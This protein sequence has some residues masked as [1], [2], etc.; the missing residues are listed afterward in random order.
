MKNTK[1]KLPTWLFLVVIGTLQACGTGVKDAESD[2]KGKGPTTPIVYADLGG[3]WLIDNRRSRFRQFEEG[4]DLSA[5][6]SA[7]QKSPYAISIDQKQNSIQI[8]DR[9][10]LLLGS[11]NSDK[12]AQWSGIEPMIGFDRTLAIRAETDV[13]NDKSFKGVFHWTVFETLTD[14]TEPQFVC[15]ASTRF[16]AT[17]ADNNTPAV[18][19]NVEAVALSKRAVKIAWQDNANNEWGY[20]VQRSL[21][22]NSD[23]VDL[24]NNGRTRAN[25]T[26]LIDR[27]ELQAGETYYYRVQALHFSGRSA[28]SEVVSVVIPEESV[29]TPSQITNLNIETYEHDAVRL[30][31]SIDS[32]FEDGI[33]VERK[34]SDSNYFVPVDEVLL[35]PGTTEFIDRAISSGSDRSV[36][37]RI[38][39]VNDLIPETDA[40]LVANYGVETD[41]DFKPEG[42]HGEISPVTQIKVDRIKER[43]AWLSWQHNAKNTFAYVIYRRGRTDADYQLVGFSHADSPRFVDVGLNRDDTYRYKIAGFNNDSTF[44]S[45]SGAYYIE[46]STPAG[47][48]ELPAPVKNLKVDSLHHSRVALSWDYDSSTST[49][50]QV[51][52]NSPDAPDQF[53]PLVY[54]PGTKTIRNLNSYNLSFV[55]NKVRNN[56]SYE[57]YVVANNYRG[58]SEAS[59]HIT[60]ET[61]LAKPST[62]TNN[63]IAPVSIV[64]IALYWT[65]SGSTQID[66][67][68]IQVSNNQIGPFVK[69]AEVNDP[70]ATM[71]QLNV[72][73]E[74]KYYRILAFNQ[75]GYSAPTSVMPGQPITGI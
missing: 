57:Y 14:S 45:P 54:I 42:L 48:S 52:R 10:G 11:I 47:A 5:C 21:F 73:S 33:F 20:R 65:P 2:D 16:T 32:E 68:E 64:S 56:N 50:Y 22:P 66:G 69:I 49:G 67:Y 75:A 53:D 28:P 15:S 58:A 43:A 36:R 39:A 18:A 3:T 8:S 1:L 63:F 62:P 51:Y 59:A 29:G 55:D 40:T 38:T 74:L 72:S 31:W 4:K 71:H 27:N 6:E 37:Y 12:T 26:L 19:T 7:I 34:Y 24:V 9:R 46:L 25:K 70:E 23:F 35:E 30:S 61:P 44:T 41:M 60:V 13:I 17:R